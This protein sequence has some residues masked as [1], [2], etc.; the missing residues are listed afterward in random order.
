MTFWQ[1]RIRL[2]F[3]SQKQT[4]AK[5]IQDRCRFG[6]QVRNL[7]YVAQDVV[8]VVTEQRVCVKHDRA[9]RRHKNDVECQL[10]H[11]PRRTKPPDIRRD[12]RQHQFD[13]HPCRGN[14]RAFPFVVQQPR[15]TDVDVQ[16]GCQH[17]HHH[18]HLVTFTTKA[19]T[20]DSVAELVQDF[21]AAQHDRKVDP[22]L[23]GKEIVERGKLILKGF[24]L[25]DH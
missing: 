11:D 24:K 14:H 13:V 16:T 5:L 25:G 3:D 2:R 23:G 12:R 4:A 17:Q 8:A 10:V 21:R 18:A 20:S 9:D 1:K 7:K 19:L 6:S 15:I 22:V